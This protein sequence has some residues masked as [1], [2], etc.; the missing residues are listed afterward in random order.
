MDGAYAP[1]KI[2]HEV[3]TTFIFKLPDG[4]RFIPGQPKQL[5]ESKNGE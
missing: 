2:E 1:E 5:P 4:T 3:V